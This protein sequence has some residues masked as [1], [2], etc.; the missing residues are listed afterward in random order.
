MEAPGLAHTPG[1]RK[2]Q[3]SIWSPEDEPSDLW[4]GDVEHLQG[5]EQGGVEGLLVR[6]TAMAQKVTEW[7]PV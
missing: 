3:E 5:C 4:L 2:G 1:E 6:A 7:G